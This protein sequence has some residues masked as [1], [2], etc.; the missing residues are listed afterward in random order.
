MAG[1]SDNDNKPNTNI[2]NLLPEVLRSDTNRTV[3][4]QSFNRH[5]TKDDTT[6][7]SGFVGEPNPTSLTKRQLPEPTPQLQAFQLQP[8]V[9]SKVGSSEYAMSFKAYQKQLELMGVDFDR[10]QQWGNTIQFNWVPPVNIDMLVNYADY[11]WQGSTPTD[12]PQYLTIENRCQK[13]QGVLSA[14]NRLVNNYGNIFPIVEMNVAENS[15]TIDGQY[16]TLFTQGFQ[17]WLKNTTDINI[18]NRFFTVQYSIFSLSTQTTPV[19]GVDAVS[20]IWTIAADFTSVLSEGIIFT[21]VGNTGGADGTYTVEN[22][23]LSGGNTSILVREPIVLTATADGTCNIPVSSC[24]DNSVPARTRIVFDPIISPIAIRSATTPPPSVVGRY[25][26]NT[27]TNDV[28][29]WDGI[30]WVLFAPPVSGDLSLEELH[31]II[32]RDTNCTC[33]GDYGWDLALWD[34]NQAPGGP[35]WTTLL[36]PYA[37]LTE[38]AWITFNGAPTA[39]ALWLDTTNDTLF[40][41]N[42]ANT[43]WVTITQ[44]WTLYVGDKLTYEILWDLTTSCNSALQV[45]NQWSQQNKWVHK[46]QVSSFGGVRRAQVPII[47]Y[48]SRAELTKW[49]YTSYTWKYRQ[50]STG[51]FTVANTVPTRLELEPIK[52]YVAVQISGSWYLYLFDKDITQARDFD[53]STIFKPG[54]KF[55]IRNNLLMSEGY[56]VDYAEYRESAPTDPV[57]VQSRYMITRIK[58]VETGAAVNAFFIA[59]PQGGGINDIRIEPQTTSRGDLWRGYHAHWVIDLSSEVQTAATPPTNNPILQRA[60]T[61]NAP[62]SFTGSTAVGPMVVGQYFQEITIG[63]AGVT[64][65]QLDSSF[66]FSLQTAYTVNGV[67]V[68]LNTWRILG[69][70]APFFTAGMSFVIPNN[71]GGGDGIYTVAS[72]THVGPNTEIIVNEVIPLSATGDGTIETGRSLVALAGQ[73]QLRVYVNDIRQYGNYVELT[74][75]GTP[76]YTAVGT[77]VYTTQSLTYVTGITFATPLQQFDIVKIEVG[78]AALVDMGTQYVPVRTVEDEGTFLLAVLAGTQPVYRSTARFERVEQTKRA[79]NQYPLFNVYDVCTNQVIMSSQIFGFREDPTEPVNPSMQRRIIVSDGG[80]EYEFQQFLLPEDNGILYG[81]RLFDSRVKVNDYWYNS[82]AQT[83]KQ[84]D[85]SSWQETFVIQDTNN[86]FSTHVP[87]VGTTPPPYLVTIPNSIWYKP[88]DKVVRRS[89]GTSWIAIAW[90]EY[91]NPLSSPLPQGLLIENTDPTLTTIWRSVNQYTDNTSG[92]PSTWTGGVY[93]PQWVSGNRTPLPVGDPLGDWEIPDQ[94][95]FNPAHYNRTYVRYSELVTHFRSI[96]SQQTPPFGFTGGGSYALTQAEF[97]Y[98]LGGT[99]KEHNDSYDTLISAVNIT[100]ATPP[101]I[102]EFAQDQYANLLL[103]IKELYVKNLQ[104][105]LTNTSTPALTGFTAFAASTVI[106]AFEANDFFGQVYVDTNAFDDTTNIGVR[107]WISTIPMFGLGFKTVPHLS[108]DKSRG[109]YEVIHHDG[110]RSEVEFTAG[111]EDS[112]ARI[113]VN[114]PDPRVTNGTLGKI[115]TTAP[116]CYM[117]TLPFVLAPGCPNTTYVAQFGIIRTGVY[118]YRTVGPRAL[119]RFNIIA[120]VP[121]PPSLVGVPEGAFYWDTTLDQ[122]FTKSAGL[123]VAAAPPGE[124]GLAWELVDLRQVLADIILEI[125]NRLYA[126]TPDYTNLVFDFSSLT[127][128]ASEQ[129]Y[130]DQYVEDQF[131]AFVREKQIRAPLE[132]LAYSPSDAFSW[133]YVNSN[134]AIPPTTYV[135][136]APAASWQELY[137]R[138]YGT[139]YPHLEPWTLQGFTNK[140][141]WWDAEYLNDDPLI[142]GNRRWKYIHATTTGMWENIRV[143]IIPLTR[144]A[145]DGSPGTGLPAQVPQ[146]YTYFSVNIGDTTISGNYVPDDVLPPY[147][148]TVSLVIRSLFTNLAA[149]IVAPASNYVYGDGGPVEWLWSVSGESVYDPSL[150]AF[151]MQPVRFMHYA[152]GEPFTRVNNLQVGKTLCEVYNHEDALFHGDVYNTNISYLV[153]GLNQWYVNYNRYV[154]YDTNKEFRILWTQWKSLLG[155]RFSGIVDTSTL[156][157]STKYFDI[158]E[159]DYNVVLSNMGVLKDMW[160]DAFEVTVL[161]MPPSV[162]Q[163]NNESQ[164]KFEINNLASVT[165]NISYYD[166]KRYPFTVDVQTNIATIFRFAIVGALA[167]AKTLE[168]EG[169]QVTTFSEQQ[170]FVISGSTNN[171][172]TYTVAGVAYDPSTNRTRITTL[173]PLGGS[174]ADGL[175]DL[176]TLSLP[177]DTTQLV[178]ITSSKTLPA[179]VTQNQPVYLIKLNS[180][181]FRIAESPNDATANNP[182]VWTTSGTGDLN[183]GEVSSSFQ[184]FGGAELSTEL[185]FHYALDFTKVRTFTPPYDIAGI[186]R[187]INIIDGYNQYAFD[188]GV[189]FNLGESGEVDPDTGRTTSWQLE[190]ERFIEWAYRLRRSR[191][192]ILDR[193]DY[194]VNSLANNQLRFTGQIPQWPAG[195]PVVVSTTGTLPDPLIANTRYFYNPIAASTPTAGFQVVD[196]GSAQLGASATNLVGGTT[197]TA[198]VVVDGGISQPISILGSAALSYTTLVAQLQSN[199]VGATWSLV[200]GNLLCTSNSVGA[201]STVAITA[202]TLFAAPLAGFIAI[203]PAIQGTSPGTFQLST[204]RLISPTTIVDLQTNGSGTLY[205]AQQ[206]RASGFPSFELNPARNN[207]WVNTPQGVL[208]N[209]IQG[210]YADIRVQQTIFDQY[211]RPLTPDKLLIYR[212]DKRSRIAI[213]EALPN[214]KVPGSISLADPYNYIHMGGAHFFI[215]GYEHVV[216]FNDYTV[217]NQIVYDPFLGLQTQRFNLNYFE[218]NDYTLRPTL[219]GFY[220]LGQQFFRNIEGQTT[221]MRNYYDTYAIQENTEVARRSRNLI[222]YRAGQMK[223][224]DLLNVNS[225]SQFIFYRGMI[226]AKGSVNSIKAYINSRRFVDA[227]LDEFWSWKIA[228]YGDARPKVYPEIKLFASDGLVDDVRLEFL[229]DQEATDSIL[230]EQDQSNGFNIITFGNQSRWI[231]EP[232][233]QALLNNSILFLDSQVSTMSKV[234]ASTTAPIAGQDTV[235]YWYNKTTGDLNVWNGISWVLAT[236]PDVMIETQGTDI[237]VLLPVAADTVRSTRRIPTTPG[238][239]RTYTTSYMNEG[240]GPDDFSRINAEVVRF[241]TVGFVG[242]ILLFT[243]NP[244]KSKISPAKLMDYKARTV[245][246]DVPVWDPARGY[247]SPVA[248]H[249]VDIQNDTDPALYSDTL[250]PNDVSQRAWNQTEATTVWFDTGSVGYLPYYD[251]KLYPDVND[252]L[253]NWGKLTDWA[254]VRVFEWVESEVTPQGWIQQSITQETDT[255]IVSNDKITG[256]PRSTTFKRIRTPLTVTLVDIALNRLT[257]ANTFTIGDQVLLITTDTLPASTPAVA[258]SVKYFVVTATPTYIQIS[259]TPGGT[260]IDFTTVGVGTLQVVPAFVAQDWVRK[261]LVYQKIIP[262]FDGYPLVTPTFTLTGTLFQQQDL[263]DVYVNGLVAEQGLVVSS[264]LQITSTLTFALQDIITVV[265]PIPI[266]IEDQLSFNPDVSDDGTI[267]EQFTS[268]IEFTQR[269]IVQPNGLPRTLYYF[270]VENRLNKIEAVNDNLAGIQIVQQLETIPTPYMVV[271]RPAD[272]PYLAER[273]G[274]GVRYGLVFSAPWI[275]D[276]YPVIPVFYRQAIIRKAADYIRADDRYAIRFTRDLTLRDDLDDAPTPLNLKNKHEEWKLIRRVQGGTIDRYLWD[277]LTE[278]IVGYKLNDPSIR[279]PSLEREL[280][281]SSTGS[282]TRFGLADQQAF[283]DGALSKQTVIAYLEDPNISFYPIDINSFFATYSF[284]T[285]A[286]T[287]TAMDALYNTFSAKHVNNI[288]FNCLEDAFSVKSKYREFFKTSWVALHG[289]R[290]LEVGGLFDD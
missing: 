2:F 266:P 202:G 221:D 114:Q 135:S 253:F 64:T 193:Y 99:I 52:G 97:D 82:D 275:Y 106:S 142:W 37:Q 256:T 91:D 219:G 150:V 104:S 67:N 241:D 84:W 27:T 212:Q 245:V 8:L 168:V 14:Y 73:D 162:I 38:A 208:S 207:I 133:N 31:D 137:T 159:Q 252:R 92:P 12:R 42:P 115:S 130:Y 58:I 32:R 183:I 194:V 11:Y 139:P 243:I 195:T 60:T 89:N 217:G 127:P 278:A 48:D 236:N 240:T 68:G 145:P 103:T 227:K 251:D 111:E 125:E 16:D 79:L 223:F 288:W 17:V 43:A 26:V 20:Q 36:G 45:L 283:T 239:L 40:Q 146:S 105:L 224:L 177:W 134:I 259:T 181:Q 179:P 56:T 174:I 276:Q 188:T 197:Y 66:R 205:V 187:L 209:V 206:Q 279:V 117:S 85:G 268:F 232:E 184:V 186:Q 10:M 213:R 9:Y 23:S 272:D 247:H 231:D 132:N 265:R 62:F 4:E 131:Y 199:T 63:A 96:V 25:W 154:G 110:H 180:R 175:I 6:L 98:S 7:V 235:D 173:E 147:Y 225:K 51:T 203:N 238:D 88:V 282:D 123:W 210:P 166:V 102:I 100:S 3:F 263:V 113:L 28:Y 112:I 152:W 220:L 1:N 165:R 19:I 126:V 218:K 160:S 255:T 39:Y 149:Q 144:F 101:S 41:R 5:L 90:P 246:A 141:L 169:D 257:V 258:T 285:P 69:N 95:R 107:H 161:S 29:R 75:T 281:D 59:N 118:W 35:N 148:S 72:A 78:P 129:A 119:Y 80:R 53:Y 22:V 61:S 21:I 260:P 185:W 120:A 156:E 18:R 170:T 237:Y 44:D 250:N 189:V 116:P 57:D 24:T 151:R 163:Y 136:P 122:L 33:F 158:V 77:S 222:G 93:V 182:F 211:S 204:S 47:E 264:T 70:H 34:D 287:V 54:F 178:F 46:S 76:E 289:I 215:E 228:E 109:I 74:S 13:Q 254:S 86:R 190:L 153:R 270:W 167:V 261:P 71:T 83:L 290:V 242:I 65:V 192:S 200:G 244:G 140:P 271:Q 108:I 198:S 269:S 87:F 280:Y 164:W 286:D 49:A 15:V 262:L 176:P 201:T 267:N 234:Y 143:G 155:Y 50:L 284:D 230:V 121:T 214:D 273:F 226:Q 128:N 30:A 277:R 157:I 55:I 138:W 216:L 124:I 196:V 249:N 233:Q 94:W 248:I 81:Y 172:G 229:T 191:V 274:Y 171:N